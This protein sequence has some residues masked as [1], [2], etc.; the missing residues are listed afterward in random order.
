[1]GWMQALLV[2][3]THMGNSQASIAQSCED[4]KEIYW[5]LVNGLEMQLYNR[6]HA[7]EKGEAS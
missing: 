7:K 2:K 6:G 1:M 5:V 4:T 3:G